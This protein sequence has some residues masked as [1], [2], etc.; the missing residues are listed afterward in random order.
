M[1][2]FIERTLLISTLIF[3]L[4][5]CGGGGNE[6]IATQAKNITPIANDTSTSMNEDSSIV[7]NLSA[8]DANGDSLSYIHS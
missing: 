4:T 7:I 2:N 1:D 8:S 5:A 6:E 3:G